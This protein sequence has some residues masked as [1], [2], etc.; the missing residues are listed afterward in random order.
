MAWAGNE[1]L[2]L[3]IT[4]SGSRFSAESPPEITNGHIPALPTICYYDTFGIE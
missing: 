2:R 1:G 4:L 3:L